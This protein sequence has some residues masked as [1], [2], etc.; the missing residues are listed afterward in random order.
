[1]GVHLIGYSS[2]IIGRVCRA[3]LQ[4]E[5]YA[6][7]DGVEE[8]MRLRVALAV[9]HGVFLRTDWEH[10]TAR[11]MRNVR[12]IDCNS[13]NDYLRNPTFM[14][15]SDKRLSIDSAA[16]RQMVCLTPDLEVREK[17]GSD[18]LDMVRW[19]DTS[20]M[21]AD[22]LTKRMRSDRLSECLRSCWLD[23]IPTDESVLCKMKDQKE[24]TSPDGNVGDMDRN[25]HFG[26]WR[27]HT[28]ELPAESDDESYGCENH[29]VL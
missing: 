23:L 8:S 4:A 19:I 13:L 22:C 28:K 27:S 18:Q 24:R 11:F 2:T 16:L 6:L 14:K 12:M 21:V 3:T 26:Q 15:C 10:H 5:T 25:D 1:M 9:A 17:I 29:R 7:S 20:C